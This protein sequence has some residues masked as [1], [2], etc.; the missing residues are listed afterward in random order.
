MTAA[1]KI[2]RLVQIALINFVIAMFFAL[3]IFEDH[4]RW[5]VLFMVLPVLLIV[6]LLIM[7]RNSKT[8][9]IRWRRLNALSVIRASGLLGWIG[10]TIYDFHWSKVFVAVFLLVL[11]LNS[12]GFF[13]PKMKSTAAE[14]I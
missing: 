11:F 5:P 14:N 1:V 10:W 9:E 8:Q 13:R 6:T 7:G 12:V 4:R 2:F 3:L